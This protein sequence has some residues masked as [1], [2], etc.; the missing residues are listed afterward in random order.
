MLTQSSG[1]GFYIYK[2]D[3]YS[4][5][6]GLLGSTADRADIVDVYASAVLIRFLTG[7]RRANGFH[8]NYQAMGKFSN[9]SKQPFDIWG[10]GSIR[11][12][13]F[14]VFFTNIFFVMA[15]RQQIFLSIIGDQINIIIK[16]T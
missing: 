8:V 13:F 11:Q 5:R 12:F 4:Y 16:L 14:V 15:I 7:T 2:Q 10:G 1:S 6:Y 9:F 3:K